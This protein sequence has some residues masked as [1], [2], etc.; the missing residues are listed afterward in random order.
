[1]AGSTSLDKKEICENLF[2]N[3]VLLNESAIKKK[4]AID[5][6]EKVVFNICASKKRD[7]RRQ[8][9][10]VS[11]FCLCATLVLFLVLMVF[12][13]TKFIDSLI[14]TSIGVKCIVPNN[15][16]VWEATRPIT[17]CQI[18]AN[19]SK[20][21]ELQN[22]S[23]EEFLQTAY[24]SQ[25]VVV[26]NASKNWPAKQLFNFSFFKEMFENDKGSYESIEEDCQFL[27]FKTN[28]PR[29]RDAFSMT[30]DRVQGLNG[31]T[32]WYIGW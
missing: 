12:T 31:T 11:Y 4:L 20:V 16:F 32:P 25:P 18:C 30:E 9:V 15:Y 28:I 14:A 5:D 26:R 21:L 6:L 27:T 19:L 8:C 24:S 22:C 3:F 17:N 29:L 13:K 2:V 1:M 23:Q 10:D 7:K